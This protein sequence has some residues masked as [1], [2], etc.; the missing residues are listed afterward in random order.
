[1]PEC[2]VALAATL[3]ILSIP[4]MVS[5]FWEQINSRESFSAA[6]KACLRRCGKSYT[7]DFVNGV[8]HGSG[9]LIYADGSVYV[10]DFRNDLPGGT[11]TMEDAD[12]WI[13]IGQ[14]ENNVKQG[15]GTHT[16]H[17]ET[18]KL[19]GTYVGAFASDKRNGEGTLTYENGYVQAGQWKNDNFLE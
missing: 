15:Q 6:V 13:Y 7:G 18:G 4:V 1:M 2:L 11:G 9:K 17:D 8:R 14:W 5:L 10:G 12:G 3:V 19:F 16:Y